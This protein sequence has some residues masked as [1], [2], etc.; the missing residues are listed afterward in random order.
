MKKKIFSLMMLAL[1]GCMCTTF[2]A[3][4]GDDDDGLP[5]AERPVLTGIRT[6]RRAATVGY[7]IKFVFCSATM[8]AFTRE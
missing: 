1:M 3:C 2:T 8:V 7:A 5:L 6:F 4:G